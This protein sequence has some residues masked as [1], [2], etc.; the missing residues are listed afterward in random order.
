MRVIIYIFYESFSFF[1]IYFRKNS[2]IRSWCKFSFIYCYHFTLFILDE[3]FSC[4]CFDD[5]SV[6]I[7]KF[8]EITGLEGNIS[9]ISEA[10][11]SKSNDSH[12]SK[13]S[14]SCNAPDFLYFMRI[15]KFN[16]EFRKK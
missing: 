5:G 8:E 2:L 3:I 4:I 16:Q 7:Y 15:H 11:D 14:W 6:S 9:S 1:K 13:S 10:I 12:E